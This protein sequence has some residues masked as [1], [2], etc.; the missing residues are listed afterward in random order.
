MSVFGT[1]VE[2]YP[3]GLDAKDNMGKTPIETA[4]EKNLGDIVTRL[5]TFVKDQ[6]MATK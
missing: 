5:E 6:S 1:I 3:D 2:A 4:R